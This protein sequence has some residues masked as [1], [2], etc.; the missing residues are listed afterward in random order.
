MS[1]LRLPWRL[2]QREVRRRPG[3]T[4]LVALLVALPVAGM[5]IAVTVIRTDH[6][7]PLEKWEESFGKA[8]GVV[9]PTYGDDG[10]ALPTPVLPA[11]SRGLVVT[12]SFQRFRTADHQH[13]ADVQLTDRPLDDPMTTGMLDVRSGR[14]PAAASEIALAPRVARD[15]GV[16][17]GDDLVL[18]RPALRLTVVGMV[19]DPVC[20][21]CRVALVAPGHLDAT[22][23]PDLGTQILVDLPELSVGQLDSIRAESV[24]LQIDATLPHRDLDDGGTEA[25]RWSL[26][27]GA[28]VL[29]VMGI[30]ISAAF[31]V[32]ARRQLV[33][34]GQLSASG[35]SPG[36]LRAGLVLQGTITGLVGA[37]GGLVLGGAALLA[38]QPQVEQVLEHRIDGYTLHLVDV[39]GAFAIG[40]LAA[41]LA[42]LLPART[43]SRLPTLAALAGRR[44][45]TP[46]PARLVAA[47]VASV[48][49]GL[50]LLGLAVVGN[51][52]GRSGNLWALVAIAGGVCE[53]AGACAIAPALVSRLEPLAARLRGSWKLAARGL[54]RNR[55]R[56][57]AVVAAVAA[58]GALAVIAAG[59]V[60][61]NAA[62]ETDVL[63][64]SAD[65]V[66]A[67]QVAQQGITGDPN[68]TYS[69]TYSLPAPGVSAELANLLPDATRT[70]LRT[71]ALA[72]TRSGD[73]SISWTIS[74]PS[75]VERF[76]SSEAFDEALVANDAVLEE[77]GL[78]AKGRELL[79]R[80]GFAWLQRHDGG[81]AELV[82]SDGTQRRVP[83][84]GAA[85]SVGGFTLLVTPEMAAELHLPVAVTAALYRSPEDLSGPT[86]DRVEDLQL[87]QGYDGSTGDS[88]VYDQIVWRYPDSGPTS[89]QLELL[90]TGLALLFSLFVVGAS[91]ALAAA[92]S[93]DER[94]ILTVAGAPPASLARAAGARAA[95]L[96]GIGGLLA[97]P[98]GFLP[99]V[100]YARTVEGHFPLIFPGRTVLILLVAVPAVLGAVAFVTSVSA[101][102]LR[103]VRVSTATFE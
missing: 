35:A 96:A 27:L 49:V 52:G 32:G 45:L 88:Y 50:S 22:F 4:V 101:Q 41:T 43:A 38:F 89:F 60:R 90:L 98:I 95:L 48:V 61:G 13:R 74:L 31:A 3:R 92:E 26:V 93:R 29:M 103:P 42:A 75:D 59:L 71:A 2:A 5:A 6:R 78:S 86:R 79:H 102:R 57:G 55:T 17:V 16:A 12:S 97:V 80:A 15:L 47:G 40:V 69:T 82:A 87:D 64:T 10:V 62:Q 24:M 36:V 51:A 73:T 33:T 19:E 37:A 9:Y 54:A 72:S 44:P 39:A 1:S 8:E 56:T 21:D 18:D 70:T 30:V 81:V 7:T 76:Q 100:V 58:A 14:A 46:V 67:R 28:V 11:G 53:L 25:V 34:L 20:L 91:L 23:G 99:V 84:I 66:M 94:D 65:V 68:G 63:Q 85:Q 77:A 83:V